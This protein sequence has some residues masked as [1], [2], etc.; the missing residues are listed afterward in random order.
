MIPIS[1]CIP[2]YNS[3]RFLGNLFD[4]LALLNP[5]PAEVVLLDD[6]SQDSSYRLA[7]DFEARAPF[8]TR[9]LRNS[10]NTGIAAAYNLLAASASQEWLHILDADDYPAEHNYYEF[11]C[12]HI[13]SN[14]GAIVTAVESNARIIT[15][16]N[17]LFGSIVPARPPQW[18]PL[19]GSFA[20][21]SGVVYRRDCALEN[22]FPDPAYPG[23]DVIQFLRMRSS[24][25][26]IYEPRAH[27]HYRVHGDA[28]SSQSRSYSKFVSALEALPFATRSMHKADLVLRRIGQG[29]SRP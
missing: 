24:H 11:I 17:R 4:K 21:R 18:C 13:S 12:S 29:L 6:A 25:Y 20:T 23:S 10:I 22:P 19:L 9:V 28:S 5:A 15:L 7:K 26:V 1:L 16:G 27:I 2:M 14:A 3:E 8:A